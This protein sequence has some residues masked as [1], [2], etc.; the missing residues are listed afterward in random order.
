[1]NFGKRLL[2]NI[3]LMALVGCI[4]VWCA[5]KWLDVWT[6]H[7]HYE[8]VPEVKGFSYADAEKRL[9]E[10]GFDVEITDSIYD[11][12]S[13][14]GTVID[15]NPKVNTK[16]KGGRM[17][18]LTI[19]AMSTKNVT[20]PNLTDVSVR[21]AKAILESL[22]IRSISVVEVESEFKD[23]VLG[24]KHNGIRINPGQ[25]IPVTSRVTLEVG[26]GYAHSTDED[27][28]ELDES[29]ADMEQLDIE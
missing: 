7:G 22:G 29:T 26:A 1:M 17:V 5:L 19:T 27:G 28:D 3:G 11:S 2:I 14:P 21:Q 16:V 4:I 24:V 6:D 13:R 18:Y 8:L 20:I 10:A 25:R 23:L 12:K 15:Q 9:R